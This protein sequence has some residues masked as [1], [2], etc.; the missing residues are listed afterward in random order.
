VILGSMYCGANPAPAASA[1]QAVT[2]YA[3]GTTI[4]YDSAA[5]ALTVNAVGAVSV[6]VQGNASVIVAGDA[7]LTAQAVTVGAQQ[8]LTLNGSLQINGNL[9]LV[10]KVTSGLKVA[11]DVRVTGAV[12][13][14]VPP[15]QL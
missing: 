4:T 13:Q 10:G 14:A 2:R 1:T 5:H 6:N 7:A 15:T 8:G 12:V 11:G 3:D 9:A